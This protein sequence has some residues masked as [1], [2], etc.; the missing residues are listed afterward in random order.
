MCRK[1]CK[2]CPWK[3]D[4]KHSKAWPS[5]VEK[6][7]SIG[8]IKDKKHACHMISTDVWGYETT[9]NENNVCVG[10]KS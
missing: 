3:S 8:R 10:P 7:E 4:T 9:I 1:P 6:L 5:Y 2:E